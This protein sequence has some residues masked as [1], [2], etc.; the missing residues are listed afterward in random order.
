MS[1]FSEYLAAIGL[2]CG[3]VAGVV[4]LVWG[5]IAV[6]SLVLAL[7]EHAVFPQFGYWQEVGVTFLVLVVLQMVFGRGGSSK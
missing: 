4:A 5:V 7:V 6:M 3:L 2:G 1:K